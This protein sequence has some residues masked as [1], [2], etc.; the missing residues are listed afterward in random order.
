MPV[1]IG[2]VQLGHRDGV[3]LVRGLGHRALDRL[4]VLVRENR[5]HGGGMR[6]AELRMG[7]AISVGVGRTLRYSS[8]G[9]QA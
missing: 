8:A 3:D 4:L 7:E 9:V 1:W 6:E 5:R 2:D